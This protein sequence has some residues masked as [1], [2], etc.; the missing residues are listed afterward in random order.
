MGVFPDI[1]Q[2]WHQYE[3][4]QWLKK[5]SQ[6]LN[7]FSYMLNI[8]GNKLFNILSIFLRQLAHNTYKLSQTLCTFMRI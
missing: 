4:I 5:L 2:G 1:C 8:I 3:G 7:T 6:C